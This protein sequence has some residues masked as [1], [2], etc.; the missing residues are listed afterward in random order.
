MTEFIFMSP[1]S[2]YNSSDYA[3]Y[4]FEKSLKM[5]ETAKLAKDND[6]YFSANNRLYYALFHAIRSVLALDK[7]DFKKHS[8]VLGYF[9]KYYIATNIFDKSFGKLIASASII[10][11]N[12][13]YED[14]Y[15]INKNE[16]EQL[17]KDTE[18]F[19]IVVK[20]YLQGKNIAL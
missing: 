5:L 4:R 18:L 12:S 13:D 3:K 19:L 8:N 20:T 10:R 9:N 6:D 2:S 16:T 7:V 1:D 11:N 17:I 15:L 14:F